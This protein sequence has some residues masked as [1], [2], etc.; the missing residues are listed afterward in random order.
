MGAGEEAFTHVGRWGAPTQTHV[1]ARVLD[2]AGKARPR[3]A[4]PAGLGWG[5]PRPE[6][7]HATPSPLHSAGDPPFRPRPSP[8]G[9]RPYMPPAPSGPSPPLQDPPH[10]RPRPPRP[11]PSWPPRPLRPSQYGGAEGRPRAA[12]P[13]ATPWRGWGT[14]MRSVSAAGAELR[15]D[16]PP[17]GRSRAG[18]LVL[19]GGI[20]LAAL[21]PLRK[22][23]PAWAVTRTMALGPR[24]A[25]SGTSGSSPSPGVRGPG[26]PSPR[27]ASG[28]VCRSYSSPLPTRPP[29]GHH[30]L[31]LGCPLTFA[32]VSLF[33]SLWAWTG[34]RG[35]TLGGTPGSLRVTPAVPPTSGAPSPPLSDGKGGV[36]GAS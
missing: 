1:G 2:L 21:A 16:P 20:A 36:V 26:R 19:G 30:R 29:R 17:G 12:V 22:L 7:A 8:T 23:R 34:L 10:A 5:R 14:E 31:R 11:H 32:A 6:A 9:P 13:R 35:R 18:P 24:G 4:A 33:L 15:G 3:K 28:P 27:P 25:V